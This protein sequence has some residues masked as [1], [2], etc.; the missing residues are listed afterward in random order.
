MRHD[1]GQETLE[2]NVTIHDRSQFEVQFTYGISAEHISQGKSFEHYRVEAYY[3]FPTNMGITPLTFPRD[4][5]YRSLHAYIRF[6]TPEISEITLL[7]PLGRRSPLNV[8][9]FHLKRFGM[10]QGLDEVDATNEARLYGC[11]VSSLMRDRVQDIRHHLDRAK[12]QA[13]DALL[14]RE[15][16]GYICDFLNTIPELL[17]KYRALIR[18]YEAFENRIGTGLIDH[19][20]QVDEYLTY[21]LD[22]TLASL[23]FLLSTAWHAPVR[24]ERVVEVMTELAEAEHQ[25]RIRRGYITLAPGD[26]AALA[27]YTYRAGAL[28]KLVDQVLYLDVK[29][30]QETARWR[31]LAAMLGAMA[32]AFFAGFS[33]RSYIMPL[34][35]HNLWLA[36]ALF[37]TIYVLKD[38]MKEFLREYVWDHVSRFFPDNKLLIEDP[39]KNIDIGRCHEK[40]RYVQKDHVSPDVLAVRNAHHAID[41][42]QERKETVVI[43][44]NDLKLYAKEILS[45]HRRRT[46]IKHILRFSVESLLSR[47]DNPTAR[48]QFFDQESRVFCRLRAPKVYHLNVVFRVTRY[49]DRNRGERPQFHRIR[50]ILDKNGIHHIDTVAVGAL[51]PDAVVASRSQAVETPPQEEEHQF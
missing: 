6:K 19:L 33:D 9:S 29:T 2:T 37:A 45:E 35:Q 17:E 22:H 44:Q 38:R 30:I 32:A 11:I 43:Y 5:F 25:H 16:E 13:N 1:N 8:L 31:N 15:L 40:V 47:L 51:S 23:H 21:R 46:Q 41:L 20:R 24:F 10:G 28:K 48:V 39:N 4:D 42:D 3:F 49:D 34:Y 14:W 26:D 12:Q 50:V 18:D 7:D 27:L 36:L